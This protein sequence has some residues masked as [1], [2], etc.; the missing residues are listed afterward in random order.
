MTIHEAG[1]H[2][3]QWFSD[4]D[5]YNPN[6]DYNNL[7][8]ISETQQEDQAAIECALESFEEAAIVKKKEIEGDVYWVL[9]KNF[10]L[11]EQ[12]IAVSAQTASIIHSHV[13]MYI[14]TAGLNDE[15]ECDPLNISE[16]DV[17]ILIDSI[18]ILSN[19]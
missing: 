11:L 1:G 5:C 8:L 4:N 13:Q 17:R 2:L 6:K 9:Q 3:Y 16:K 19:K 18:K 14:D 7:V 12:S 10:A 15:Y